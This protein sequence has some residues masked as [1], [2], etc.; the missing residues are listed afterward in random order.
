MH[1]F[2][3][4]LHE[5][6]TTEHKRFPAVHTT[7]LSNYNDNYNQNFLFNFLVNVKQGHRLV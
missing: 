4:P 5:H 7:Y 1:I 2:F 3:L 6:F